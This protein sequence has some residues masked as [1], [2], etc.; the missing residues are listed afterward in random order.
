MI[1]ASSGDAA[2][3]A[4]AQHHPDLV[5]LDIGI[6]E[7]NGFEV[8][9]RLKRDPATSGIPIMFM[10][11]LAPAALEIAARELG[12]DDYV[13]KPIDAYEIRLRIRHVLERARAAQ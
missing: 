2:L 1:T 7:P 4:A 12:A 13:A 6:P 8:C 11:G 5:L 9:R 3:A 10:S